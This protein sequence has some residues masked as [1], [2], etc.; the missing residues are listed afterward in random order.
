MEAY[1][2]TQVHTYALSCG[3]PL[4]A[5]VVTWFTVT[6]LV[7]IFENQPFLSIIYSTGTRG[8]AVRAILKIGAGYAL[9]CPLTRES[10][11]EIR[12]IRWTVRWFE[13]Q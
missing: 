8:H 2:N 7:G 1:K 9:I 10:V 3:S 4:G 13:K 5:V 11:A 12:T 6:L